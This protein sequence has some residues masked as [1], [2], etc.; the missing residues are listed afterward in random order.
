MVTNDINVF[1]TLLVQIYPNCLLQRNL[2]TISFWV[3]AKKYFFSVIKY[4]FHLFFPQRTV[5]YTYSPWTIYWRMLFFI[6]KIF[7][8]WIENMHCKRYSRSSKKLALCSVIHSKRK[9]DSSFLIYL[10]PFPF[11]LKTDSNS[12][13]YFY[14]IHNIN[15]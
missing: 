13:F 15:Y 8:S 5:W 1:S 10:G 6:W 12:F 4:N 2:D 9:W 3:N 14:Q 11:F 7:K